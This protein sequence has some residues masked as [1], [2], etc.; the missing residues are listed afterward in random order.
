MVLLSHWVPS[1]RRQKTWFSY[2]ALIMDKKK[3]EIHGSILLFG[4]YTS[5]SF[6]TFGCL[7]HEG[8]IYRNTP[9]VLK[10]DTILLCF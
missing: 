5:G 2:T 4:L 3:F 6:C 7:E 8:M 1:P 10:R 9:I